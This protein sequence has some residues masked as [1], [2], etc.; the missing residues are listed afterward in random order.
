MTA[1]PLYIPKL[2]SRRRTLNQGDSHRSKSRPSA[3]SKQPDRLPQVR[4]PDGSL[5]GIQS[6]FGRG[7]VPT[8]RATSLALQ[9]TTEQCAV[10]ACPSVS[11]PQVGISK[12]VA[13]SR[14]PAVLK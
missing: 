12:R 8:T 2:G 7:N 3:P 14:E 5:A 13:Q 4:R 9:H 6:V 10:T 11:A 1:A